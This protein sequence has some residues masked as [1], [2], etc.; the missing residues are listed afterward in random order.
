MFK[1]FGI[2]L[3]F[4]P[5]VLNGDM[6]NLKVRPEVS[7]LD[8]SSAITL[9][10][11]RVPALST[12]RTETEVEL[13]NGQTFAIAG[14]MNNTVTNTMR[15]IPGIGDIPILGWLFKSKAMAKNQTELVV[16]ITPTIVR[17]GSMGVS[18]GVPSAIEPYLGAPKK[19]LPQPEPW[20]GSPR[21]PA[22]QPPTAQKGTQE[23]AQ[24][25]VPAQPTTSA[26]P[27]S[28]VQAAVASTAAKVEQ[29]AVAPA[30]APAKAEP[31]MDPKEATRQREAQKRAEED[32]KRTE[33]AQKAAEKKAADEKAIADKKAAE[34]KAEADRKAAIEKARQ[35]KLDAERAKREAEVAKK[36]ADA[37]KKRQDELKKHEKSVA[38]AAARLKQAQAAYQ[39]EME[40]KK[41][42][43]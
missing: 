15:T 25:G 41:G 39:A 6:I 13:A 43:Q 20:K 34:D 23:P 10:G 35:D 19:T 4:T 38:D 33:E 5:T 14:L 16:M 21:Y 32:Q 24:Q 28:D 40:K 29:Q 2:R 11:F 9:S 12:R 30:P 1:E 37:E 36:N 18:E 42:I 26:P 22:N 31:K 7:A 8:F 17:K 27:M 3:N